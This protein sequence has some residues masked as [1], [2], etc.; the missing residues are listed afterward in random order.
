MDED[1]FD[2]NDALDCILLSQADN[3]NNNNENGGCLSL[4]LFVL[5]PCSW[6]LLRLWA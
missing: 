4:I 2:E 6:A 3:E 1:I 5:L